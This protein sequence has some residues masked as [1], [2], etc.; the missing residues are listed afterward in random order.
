MGPQEDEIEGEESHVMF[1]LRRTFFRTGL[2]ECTVKRANGATGTCVFYDEK[3]IT[4]MPAVAVQNN[5][6]KPLVFTWFVVHEDGE[7]VG[8]W[9][10]SETMYPDGVPRSVYLSATI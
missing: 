2:H 4:G 3:R 7:F 1:Y 6:P 5:T 8:A 10:G 9:H